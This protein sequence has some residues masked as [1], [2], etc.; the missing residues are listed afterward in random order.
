MTTRILSIGIDASALET[1]CEVLKTAGYEAQCAVSEEAEDVLKTERFNLV[2]LSV[3]LTEDD[4][5]LFAQLAGDEAKVLRLET[6]VMPNELL[7][8]VR[9]RLSLNARPTGHPR[10][11]HAEDPEID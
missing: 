2:I 9:E 4:K 1:R 3:F 10:R 7:Q 6:L 11:S 8:L 5:A